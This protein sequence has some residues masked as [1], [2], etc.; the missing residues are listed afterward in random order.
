METRANHLLIGGFVIALFFG[1]CAF[2]IWLAN[3]QG[4]QVFDRYHIIYKG[5]VGGLKSGSPVNYQGVSVGQVINVRL[6]PGNPTEEILIELEVDAN[7]PVTTETIATLQHQGITGTKTITLA[8][9]GHDAEALENDGPYGEP[10]IKAGTSAIEELLEGAPEL[11]ANANVLLAQGQDLLNDE[12]RNNIAQTLASIATITRVL[13]QQEDSLRA[14]IADA[15]QTTENVR[16]ITEDVQSVTRDFRDNTTGMAAE[17]R[18]TLQAINSAAVQVDAL[19]EDSAPDVR[20]LL[21]SLNDTAR[22][23]ERTSGQLEEM[24][25]E[26]RQPIQDFAST[27]LYE[28]SS[29]L[30]ETRALIQ[31]IQLLTTDIKRDPARFFFGDA[32][33]GFVAGE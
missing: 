29:L 8:T 18:E 27:G 5:D 13:A 24:L 30:S 7:T 11:I 12:N 32:Q 20:N 25:R 15:Q 3:F 21:V 23:F 19:V 16:L 14:L 17:A 10:V 6:A 26:N 1:A 22:S 9:E 2:V 28:L 31:D 33:D 4:D